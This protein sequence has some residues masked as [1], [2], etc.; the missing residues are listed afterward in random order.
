MSDLVCR[1]FY[2]F[3]DGQAAEL[4]IF[5]HVSTGLFLLTVPRGQGVD[6]IGFKPSVHGV[7][8]GETHI[9]VVFSIEWISQ[10][11]YEVRCVTR[12]G[13]VLVDPLQ[14]WVTIERVPRIGV[15]VLT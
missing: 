8:R 12:N 6:V 7:G 2:S 5:Q 1:A 14:M 11:E 4:C 3:E 13:G 9:P 10:T 15:S